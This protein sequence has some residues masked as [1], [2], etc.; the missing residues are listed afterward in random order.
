MRKL[1]KV[2]AL[3]IQP[4]TVEARE[5]SIGVALKHCVAT[6]SLGTDRFLQRDV[7]WSARHD[8]LGRGII[9]TTDCGGMNGIGLIPFSRCFSV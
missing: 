9:R 4:M 3:A 2:C 6:N 8:I 7:G 1:S 5:R